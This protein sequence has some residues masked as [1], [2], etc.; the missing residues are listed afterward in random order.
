MVVGENLI[1]H[2]YWNKFKSKWNDHVSSNSFSKKV[3]KFD[4]EPLNQKD[5]CQI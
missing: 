3:V 1:F 5:R 4:L 2:I